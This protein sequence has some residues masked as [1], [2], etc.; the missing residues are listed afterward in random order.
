VAI[1]TLDEAIAGA[2]PPQP[3]QKASFTG[4]AAGRF[5]NLMGVAGRPAA[6]ALGS[7]G[8]AGATVDN[9]SAIGGFIPFTNPSGNNAYLHR[10]AA[11]NGA[12]VVGVMLFDL[13]W[14]NTGITVTT[15][16]GQTINSVAWPARDIA[17]STNGDGVEIWLW[18]SA[19]IGGSAVTN[20]TITY[21][22]Q[23]GTG[24]A[25]GTLTSW[26]AT[27]A[28]GTMEPFNLANGD[29]GVRSV[30]TLTLGTTY[31]SGTLNLLAIRKIATLFFPAAGGQVLDVVGTGMPRLYSGSA[32][33][34][35]LL[36]SGTAA[37]GTVG[38]AQFTYG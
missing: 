13:L 32:L 8:L 1:S 2:V 21:T 38:E 9:T 5:H 22:D 17:G 6:V 24:G 36:L 26:P 4:E 23:G 15:T 12:N 37:G 27:A 33:Y 16:T 11:G 31:T 18:A 34:C 28:A 7:P 10:F 3:I 25:T 20:T 14:Y 19:A 30:Q 35:A 29:T